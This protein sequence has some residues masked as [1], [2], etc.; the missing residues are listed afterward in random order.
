VLA[1]IDRHHARI[2]HVHAK[3]VRLNVIQSLDRARA[4]FLD[5]VVA[6]AFTVPGDGDLDFALMA[7][8]LADVGYE[9][10]FVVEAEQDPRANPPARMAA[11]GRAE[12]ARVLALA[13]YE[14]A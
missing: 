11:L 9:G 6:G 8:R 4:S 12:L 10:W 5:A 3:D 7:R 13:G 14:V 1:V 2:N